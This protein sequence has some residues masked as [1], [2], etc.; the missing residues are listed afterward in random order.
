MTATLISPEISLFGLT[1]IL[2]A[3]QSHN[4]PQSTRPMN[5]KKIK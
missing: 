4:E 2:R 3:E 5:R 1:F